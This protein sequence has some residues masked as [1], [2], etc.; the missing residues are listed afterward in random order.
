[1]LRLLV[2]V[3]LVL[4]I[5]I[6]LSAL[7]ARLRIALSAPTPEARRRSARSAA[8]TSR[9]AEHLVRCSACGVRVPQSRALPAPGA[10]GA[11]E[12]AAF[13]SEACRRQAVRDSA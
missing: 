7:L 9:S 3:L 4:L 8:G 1:M 10:R 11:T 2:L 5:W 12:G 13:C 6:F